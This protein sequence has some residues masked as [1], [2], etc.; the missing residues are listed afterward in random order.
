MVDQ[1]QE[2]DGEK[3]LSQPDL[4]RNC[5]RNQSGAAQIRFQKQPGIKK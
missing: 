3:S 4:E 5:P 1:K 2:Q